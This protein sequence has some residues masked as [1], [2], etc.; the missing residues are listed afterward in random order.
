MRGWF[1]FVTPGGAPS[2]QR[3]SPPDRAAGRN[4]GLQRLLLES[5]ILI[6][7][8]RGAE[9]CPRHPRGGYNFHA[10]EICSLLK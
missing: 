10:L 4:L 1:G 8:I 9:N 5:V 6:P 3:L 7:F 2:A